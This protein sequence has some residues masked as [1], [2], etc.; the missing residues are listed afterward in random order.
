M[1]SELYSIRSH[2]SRPEHQLHQQSPRHLCRLPWGPGCRDPRCSLECRKKWAFREAT[3]LVRLLASQPPEVLVYFGNLAI[4]HDLT[5]DQHKPIRKQFLKALNA[6]GKSRQSK[7]RLYV[8]SEIGDDLRCH[9]HY[10]LTSTTPV[11][12]EV[13]KGLWDEA[14]G[15]FATTVC[16]YE[17]ESVPACSRY[18]FKSMEQRGY[19]HLFRNETVRLTW[20]HI[21]KN[22]FWIKSKDTIWKNWI[23]ETFK[24]QHECEQY[25]ERVLRPL[26]EL[27]PEQ[28]QESGHLR[29]DQ[30]H[31]RQGLRG[32]ERKHGEP[33]AVAHP[34]TSS[35]DTQVQVPASRLR[36]IPLGNVPVRGHRVRRG[37]GASVSPGGRDHQE[38]STRSRCTRRG[39]RWTRR[40]GGEP[41]TPN[42]T[43]DTSSTSGC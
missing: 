39:R 2:S 19:V 29:G 10:S 15:E 38:P 3:C 17:P 31:D 18:M 27:R 43:R 1:S 5:A 30:Q 36:R 23:T 26:Q 6:W 25:L 7:L 35:R 22:G 8:T 32:T 21:G 16:H 13:V 33:G 20:G 42:S 24:E 40:L 4:R 41:A 34:Q 28:R 9:Y 11:S 14:C 37:T 12:Q